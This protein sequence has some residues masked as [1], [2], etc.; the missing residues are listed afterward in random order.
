MQHSFGSRDSRS[1][2]E[3]HDAAPEHHHAALESVIARVAVLELISALQP[4]MPSLVACR[5]QARN[6][7]GIVEKLKAVRRAGGSRRMDGRFAHLGAI[8]PER[9]DCSENEDA[10]DFQN[11]HGGFRLAC[12]RDDDHISRCQEV[13]KNSDG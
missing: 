10:D 5:L 6:R 1:Y 9:G 3:D 2:V 4:E 12:R 13:M 8:E 11:G 7:D